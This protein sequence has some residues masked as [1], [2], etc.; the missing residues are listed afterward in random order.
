MLLCGAHLNWLAKIKMKGARAPW[1][2]IIV[3]YCCTCVLLYAK[4]LKE[5]ETE[6]AKVFFVTILSLAAF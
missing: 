5:N 4:M 1:I 2:S 6:E 3:D